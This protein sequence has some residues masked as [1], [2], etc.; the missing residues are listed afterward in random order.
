MALGW[1][2]DMQ[3][4]VAMMLDSVGSKAKYMHSGEMIFAYLT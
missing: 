2:G 4:W 1:V 3:Y